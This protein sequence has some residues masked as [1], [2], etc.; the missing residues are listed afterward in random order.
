MVWDYYIFQ[1]RVMCPIILLFHFVFSV[2]SVRSAFLGRF[3]TWE[4]FIIYFIVFLLSNWLWFH[5]FNDIFINLGWHSFL[6]RWDMKIKWVIEGML[7]L[8]EGKDRWPGYAYLFL[9]CSSCRA[10][11]WANEPSHSGHALYL[12][13]KDS[14]RLPNLCTESL[15]Q[16][17]HRIF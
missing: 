10:L 13:L 16:N 2:W 5:F 17:M 9:G 14:I 8:F 1:N 11:Y 7:I 4:A 15:G 6:T 3:Y 12:S